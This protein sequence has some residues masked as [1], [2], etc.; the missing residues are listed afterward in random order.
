MKQKSLLAKLANGSLVIQILLGIIA[1]VVLANFSPDSAK[2]I[3]FL[4]S[5]FVGA[6]KAIAP[7]LVF[8]LVA[9]SIA[10]QKKNTQTNMRPI[11][12]LYLFG[13]F[14]AALTAVIL[15][16]IFPTDLVLVAGV[17]GTSPPQGIGEVINTLL[18][19]LV[20]NPVNALMTGN[21]IGILAWGVGLGLALHHATDSTKQVFADMSHGI[22]QMVRFIIRLAP[23]GIFGLVAAT[24]AETGFAAIAGYAQLLAV[25]LGAMAIIALIVN[26]LI[27][28][29]K[30]RRN[31]YPLVF[32]CL[33]ESGVTAF[34]TRSS[35][36]NIPVN[37]AL[38]EKLNLH[39]DT[40]S[41]SIPLGATINMGGAAITITVLTL[42][43]AHTLGIQVD[44]LTALLLSVV[45]A[46]SACGASGVAGGS[47]LLIPLACSLF[48]ISNDVAMQVV[49]VGFIIGVVQDAA[50]TALNSSTDVIFTAAAC[51][52]AE[53][54]AKLS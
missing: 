32:Q 30:I 9:S 26:P 6:L 51:E 22:S 36:A 54:K 39:E 46:V 8:I 45:A 37:M 4:G 16:S 1:G 41:V 25:L 7:I 27:V 42:A 20:D 3:A 50:E 29:V 40:Y 21:Y 23:I 43:A 11:V 48:G 12:V 14:A 2:D 34:F 31:P 44:L 13:T 53:N 18:F 15:S 17:E 49:A 33:R 19:K 35:A 10:N 38:C 24:F 52:A 47:L 28:Y 5:L